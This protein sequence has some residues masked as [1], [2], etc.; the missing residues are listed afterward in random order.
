MA[1]FNNSKWILAQPPAFGEAVPLLL[2]EPVGYDIINHRSL[3]DAVA[4][5][6]G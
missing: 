6:K 3:K 2:E 5:L 1:L 4:K